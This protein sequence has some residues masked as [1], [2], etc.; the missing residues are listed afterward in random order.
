MNN[1]FLSI[2]SPVYKAE[3]IVDELVKRITAE[4][5]ELTNNFEII[6][7]EDGSPDHCWE[8]I[9][10]NCT[11][12]KRVKGIK[13]SRNFG[14]HYAISAGLEA[15]KGDY[16]VIMDCDLQ[17]DPADIKRLLEK[18]E[19]GCDT[20]FTRRVGRKH[21]MGKMLLSW[22]YKKLFYFI[23]KKEYSLD[24]G[25]LFLINRKVVNAIIHLKEKPRLLGQVIRWVGFQI[26]FVDVPHHERFQGRSSYSVSKLLALVWDGWI[27]N[28]DRLLR[29]VM[30]FGISISTLSF[31]AGIIII[32]LKFIN[33]FALGWPSIIV[34]ILFS[35]GLILMGLGVVGLYVGKIFEQTKERPLFIVDQKLNL[36]E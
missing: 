29:I 20:V 36:N 27:S 30:Y 15:S 6:L 35:T 18:A 22:L 13:L 26:G 33:G 3:N 17:D 7:I 12:D 14:Q 5:E 34:T 28:S 19:A 31:L 8:K 10:E 24:N 1:P 32:V 11:R 9:K 21:S 25:S 23:S 4:A 2:I 16:V